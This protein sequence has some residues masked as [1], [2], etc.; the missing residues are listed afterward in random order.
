LNSLRL[1]LRRGRA[2]LEVGDNTFDGIVELDN[3]VVTAG[4][5]SKREK[6]RLRDCLSFSD[7]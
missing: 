7:V 2:K 1:H 6:N 5:A 4:V 3:L